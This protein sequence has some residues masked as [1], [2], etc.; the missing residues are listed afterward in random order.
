MVEPEASVA[1]PRSLALLATPEEVA[2]AIE[3]LTYKELA[4]RGLPDADAADGSD[5]L[6]SDEHLYLDPAMHFP[7]RT[8]PAS[9]L[10]EDS[11]EETTFCGPSPGPSDDPAENYL[12]DASC[13]DIQ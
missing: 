13:L 10:L 9:Q 2:S 5:L 7:R 8:I 4:R 3:A 6:E 12:V 1:C 11:D